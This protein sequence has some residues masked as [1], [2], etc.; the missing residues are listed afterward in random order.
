MDA[1][2][3]RGTGKPLVGKVRISGAKN[4]ALPILCSSLLATGRSVYRNV[5]GLGD[6]RTMGKL[7][8][9]LGAGFQDEGGG[10][11]RVDTSSV[12]EY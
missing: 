8:A 2:R 4:A 11:A 9:R 12:N 1:L 7:L 10:I 3:V 5:P 6:V